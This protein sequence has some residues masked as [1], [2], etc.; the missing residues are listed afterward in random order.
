LTP[1]WF[2][3][4]THSHSEQLVYDQLV[5]K[6]FDAYAPTVQTW[7]RRGGIRRLIPRPLFP[8]YLFVR[9]AMDKE[10]YIEILKAR[11]VVRVLGE[12]WDRLAPIPDAEMIA[13]QQVMNSDLPV[14]PH[15]HLQEGQ[16]VRIDAGPLAGVEGIFLRSRPQRGLLVLSVELLRQSISV[17]VDCTVVSPIAEA[18]PPPVQAISHATSSWL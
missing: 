15:P 9:R 5:A 16:R 18:L 6:G 7:S 3:I 8:S 1:Q 13:L 2:A 4:W 11:G 12:R 17:E 14:L 10:S